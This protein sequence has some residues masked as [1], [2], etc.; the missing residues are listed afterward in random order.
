MCV[1]SDVKAPNPTIGVRTAFQPF[2]DDVEAIHRRRMVRVDSE[3]QLDLFLLISY[4]W[5]QIDTVR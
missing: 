3:S 2:A 5:V 1:H 4:V